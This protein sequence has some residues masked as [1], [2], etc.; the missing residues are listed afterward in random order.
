MPAP[1][2]PG[3]LNLLREFARLAQI[4]TPT[5]DLNELARMVTNILRGFKENVNDLMEYGIWCLLCLARE[6]STKSTPA[7]LDMFLHLAD[8]STNTSASLF[9]YLVAFDALH[10]SSKDTVHNRLQQMWGTYGNPTLTST[11]RSMLES[12]KGTD[13]RDMFLMTLDNCVHTTTKGGSLT[14]LCIDLLS[15]NDREDRVHLNALSVFVR[16]I[17]A[18]KPGKRDF[19]AALIEAFVTQYDTMRTSQAGGASGSPEKKRR[20]TGTK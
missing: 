4:P 20:R 10:C 1:V 6:F 19:T 15:K 5:I 9:L 16:V 11:F 3:V 7:A 14:L 18:M 13:F 8:S 2:P 17:R 12:N